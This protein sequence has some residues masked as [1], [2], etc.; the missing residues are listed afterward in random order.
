MSE[1]ALD[2]TSY[3]DEH[4]YDISGSVSDIQDALL[5]MRRKFTS[6]RGEAKEMKAALL[7]SQSELR[8]ATD[9]HHQQLS[10]LRKSTDITRHKITK[11]LRQAK[12]AQKLLRLRNEQLNKDLEDALENLDRVD[13]LRCDICRYDFKKWAA[14]CGHGFCEECTDLYLRT[15]DRKICPSCRQCYKNSEF[16]KL[17]LEPGERMSPVLVDNDEDGKSTV[18]LLSD[19]EIE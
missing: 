3:L 19:G 10:Q 17:Y 7:A 6:M 18:I 14:N 1:S 4:D 11:K 9:Q 2:V 8:K 12:D 15:A 5:D 13:H 16:R